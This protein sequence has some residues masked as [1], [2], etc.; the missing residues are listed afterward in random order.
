MTSAEK[1]LERA[2]KAAQSQTVDHSRKWISTHVD[3]YGGESYRSFLHIMEGTP[4]RAYI[5]ENPDREICVV[6]NIDGDVLGH[7]VGGEFDAV[8]WVP[9]RKRKN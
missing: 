1:R 8:R 7:V 6:I 2:K 9:H 4:P 3:S 5:V